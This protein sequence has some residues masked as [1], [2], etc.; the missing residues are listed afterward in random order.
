MNH[1]VSL[2]LAFVIATLVPNAID[3]QRSAV[4]EITIGEAKVVAPIDVQRAAIGRNGLSM[5]MALRDAAGHEYQ[6]HQ[7]NQIKSGTRNVQFQPGT[8]RQMRFELFPLTHQAVFMIEALRTAEYK[9]STL[10]LGDGKH[11][12]TAKEK[13]AIADLFIRALKGE[14][15]RREDYSNAG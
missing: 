4:R 2:A 14:Y 9:D 7:T 1:I 13:R 8:E 12:Y 3:A 11:T 5:A 6:L 10:P 15:L